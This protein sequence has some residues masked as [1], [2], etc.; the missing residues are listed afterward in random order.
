MDAKKATM[1]A[2]I[3]GAV[4]LIGVLMPWYSISVRV[5]GL[6]DQGVGFGGMA[7][8]LNGTEGGYHGGFVI[9]LGVIAGLA[10]AFLWRGAP[11]ALPV[12]SRGLAVIAVGGFGLATLVTLIDVFRDTGNVSGMRFPGVDFSAGRGAGMFITLLAAAAGAG[13]SFLALRG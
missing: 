10:A 6:G 3:C 9:V 5:G 12:S 1:L 2:A 11:K 7:Q 13:L 4:I 8:S